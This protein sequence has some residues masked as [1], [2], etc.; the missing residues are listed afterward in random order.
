MSSGNDAR[1]L[2]V[3]NQLPQPEQHRTTKQ[4]STAELAVQVAVPIFRPWERSRP[5]VRPWERPTA[6]VP[7]TVFLPLH[8]STP[9]GAFRLHQM[10]A[11]RSP[12]PLAGVCQPPVFV[13]G[14]ASSSC[15]RHR[16][17][18]LQDSGYI[19]TGQASPPSEP[20]DV[21]NFLP[22]TSRSPD[23]KDVTTAAPVGTGSVL[24]KL[25][26][27]QFTMETRRI[28]A[29]WYDDHVQHPVPNV[30]EL[31]ELAT[32]AGVTV[33][34]TRKYF[35]NRRERTKKRKRDN[36]G[37]FVDVAVPTEAI[38]LIKSSSSFGHRRRWRDCVYFSSICST[39]LSSKIFF[40]EVFQ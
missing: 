37:S 33:Q 17:S 18:L 8:A 25:P 13:F 36:S 21:V 3:G 9:V 14:R 15:V 7:A 2:S 20:V 39:Y 16:S 27:G 35:N 10:P 12:P 22:L 34:Q 11:F 23:V 28:F 40:F 31:Q 19:S 6:D 30:D 24:G 38:N 26:S 5:I 4:L 1:P 32:A 29:R